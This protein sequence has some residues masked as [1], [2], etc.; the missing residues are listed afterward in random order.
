MRAEEII[1][2]LDDIVAKLKMK[3]WYYQT[4]NQK[5]KKRISELKKIVREK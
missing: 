5:L 1:E 2:D 4:E 3:V